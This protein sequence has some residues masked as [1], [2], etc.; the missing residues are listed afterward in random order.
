MRVN[1]VECTLLGCLGEHDA[2]TIQR[3][4]LEVY[5]WT[6]RRRS[7]DRVRVR[8]FPVVRIR[9]RYGSRKA[10]LRR[11]WGMLEKVPQLNALPMCAPKKQTAFKG[12]V[13]GVVA[14]RA[15]FA[16]ECVQQDSP[17]PLWPMC[18][19]GGTGCREVKLR[20]G[21][22]AGLQDRRGPVLSASQAASIDAGY[23]CKLVKV[24]A[25]SPSGCLAEGRACAGEGEKV[26]A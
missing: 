21:P 13:S 10:K 26:Q 4:R 14:I 17:C 7:S 3:D 11:T 24:S 16:S 22:D 15:S 25:A 12:T 20:K 19:G 1:E 18:F 6:L 5:F 23:D 2:E 8:F 9:P